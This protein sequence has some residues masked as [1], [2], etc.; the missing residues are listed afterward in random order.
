MSTTSKQGFALIA[1]IW[2]AGMIATI[3]AVFAV[4]VRVDVLTARAMTT[5]Q[6]LSGVADGLARLTAWQLATETDKAVLG[7]LSRVCALSGG[8]RAQLIVQDQAGLIDLNTMPRSIFSDL[9][10]GLGAT[11]D[12]SSNMA[13]ALEDFRDADKLSAIGGN[14]P[15]RYDGRAFGPKNAPFQA[16]EE[17]EQV[18]GMTESLYRKSLPFVTVY[19]A[20]YGIDP[21]TAPASLR[22]LFGETQVNT[23]TGPLAAYTGPAQGKTFAVDVTVA[24]PHGNSFHRRAIVVILRQPDKPFA[25]LEWQRL[26]QSTEMEFNPASTTEQSC[27]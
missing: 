13:S 19:S 17:L 7:N 20:Q 24:A 16:I 22:Q 11:P 18:P 5:T 14:E 15:E 25:I 21:V 6:Q 10:K 4:K 1:V 26:M 27:Y 9:F 23:F 12:Q 2:L 3:G 8:A